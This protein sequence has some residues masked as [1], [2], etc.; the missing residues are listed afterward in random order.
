MQPDVLRDMIVRQQEAI[1]ALLGMPR[2]DVFVAT[3]QIVGGPRAMMGIAQAQ[4][5]ALDAMRRH[6]LLAEAGC[7][8]DAVLATAEKPDG[9]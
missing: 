5:A 1:A 3:Y 2:G 9:R 8:E 4:Q 7:I 6:T